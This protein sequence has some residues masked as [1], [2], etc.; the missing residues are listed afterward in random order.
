MVATD[1]TA[2]LA[3][4]TLDELRIALAPEVAVAAMFDGWTDAAL[5]S[6]AEM[7]GVEPAVARLAFK[8]GAMGMIDA[9]VASVDARMEAE[10]ANGR[11]DNMPIREK[12]RVLVWFRLEAIM[13][14]EESLRR[15]TAVQAMPQN[16]PKTLK[17]GWSSADKMWRLAGDTATDYNHYTKRAIL[18]SIYGATLAVFVEDESEG[19]ADTA[20]FLDR[21]IEGV[22][23]FEKAKA[24][25]LGKDREHFDFA[26]FL[27]RLR[28][29][30]K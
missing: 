6:A 20:A 11:L 15:A 23:K 4:A 28:Y 12:I 22:M 17:Q 27:G 3:D 7:S 18:G 16:V 8:D 14:L 9:W 25:L 26:R 10:F 24:Q 2:D 13:G 30:Q 21:R 1:C 5:V 29:P 19:K